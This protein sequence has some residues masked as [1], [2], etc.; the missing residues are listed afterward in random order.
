M[1]GIPIPPSRGTRGR[2]TCV[3]HATGKGNA[4]LCILRTSVRVG[5]LGAGGV[6]GRTLHELIGPFPGTE[7][8][9]EFSQALEN[10]KRLSLGE[11]L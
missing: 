11:K 1:I 7:K 2:S 3:S 6:M 8:R 5:G 9:R 10:A 4:P